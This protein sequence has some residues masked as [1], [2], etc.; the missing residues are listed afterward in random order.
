MEDEKNPSSV[1]L[2]SAATNGAILGLISI[3]FVVITY[4]TGDIYKGN[5]WLSVLSMVISIAALVYFALS[6]RKTACGGFITYGNAFIYCWLTY[7]FAGVLSI[8]FMVLLQTVIEPN[9]MEKM[10][11]VQ[12]EMLL[13]K[14]LSDSQVEQSIAMASKFQTPLY[15]AIIGFLGNA[16]VGLVISLITAI[17]VKK[18]KPVF[19]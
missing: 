12:R 10:A 11:D 6:Y 2:K 18:D 16:L 3:L 14:G 17:F 1:M 19:E 5:V 15:I 9:Y 7:I 4:M 8:A 13:K